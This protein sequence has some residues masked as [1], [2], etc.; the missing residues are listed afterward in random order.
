MTQSWLLSDGALRDEDASF[1]ARQHFYEH[2]LQEK[3]VTVAS[4]RRTDIH[5]ELFRSSESLR[6]LHRGEHPG[7][8]WIL[9]VLC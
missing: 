5:L 7:F 8:M 2:L 1:I 4:G 3:I 9:Q 6:L